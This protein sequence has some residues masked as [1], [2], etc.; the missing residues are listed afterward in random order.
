MKTSM[1]AALLVTLSLA[2]WAQD[3]AAPPQP[4]MNM[5]HGMDK[6]PQQPGAAGARPGGP[7]SPSQADIEKMQQQMNE[8][9]RTTDPKQRLK[10]MQE[11]MRAM[12]ANMKAMRA[13]GNASP[14]GGGD[15]QKRQDMMERRMDMM[16]DMMEQMMQRDKAMQPMGH[17]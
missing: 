14:K 3:K 8:I 9:A 12:E 6:T 1:V 5:D 17:M 11:H 2:G 10:L 15:M 7:A 16:Q 13:M 4:A